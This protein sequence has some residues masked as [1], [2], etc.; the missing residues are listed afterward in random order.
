[1]DVMHARCA[2]LDVHERVFALRPCHPSARNIYSPLEAKRGRRSAIRGDVS[3]GRETASR[4][5]ICSSPCSR[6]GDV[7]GDAG[8]MAEHL[9]EVVVITSRARHQ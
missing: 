3:P 4:P 5:A 8:A 2:G 9:V 1:M 7:P 6:E